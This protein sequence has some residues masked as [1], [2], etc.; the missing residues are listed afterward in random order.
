M[1]LGQRPRVL[2][3]AAVPLALIGLGLIV[4]VDWSEL[5]D[6][7]RRGVIFGLLTAVAYAGYLL[8][9]RS[10]RVGSPDPLPVRE[11]AVIS[12]AAT[13]LLGISALLEGQSLGIPSWRDA[14]WLL[15]YGLLSHSL[16]L[17]FIASSLPHVS[18]TQAG[19]ALLLQPTL[20]FVWDIVFFAR[21]LTFR[22]FLGAIIALIAIYLGS[23]STH[24]SSSAPGSN[25]ISKLDARG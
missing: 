16:G 6:D 25:S 8:S 13:V 3:V 22:E 20:S 19:I 1:F 11:I 2:Q 21:P 9:M 15:A 5:A 17:M 18:T 23:R 24:R 10:A 7:Y 12:V 14:G 4:G